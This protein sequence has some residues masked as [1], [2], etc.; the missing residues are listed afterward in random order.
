MTRLLMA[1]YNKTFLFLC[2]QVSQLGS[3]TLTNEIHYVYCF[4]VVI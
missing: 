2:A 3:G 1:L 4:T